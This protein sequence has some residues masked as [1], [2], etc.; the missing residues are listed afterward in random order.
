[1][2]AVGVKYF[3]TKE[4]GTV[5]AGTT[6][7]VEFSWH[8]TVRV[9]RIFFI[10]RSGASLAKVNVT[11]KWGAD[12]VITRESVPASIFAYDPSKAFVLDRELKSDLLVKFSFT[13]NDS[14]DKDLVIVFECY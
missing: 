13:N 9:H 2:I 8:E 3:I 11:I 7:D 4:V 1:M 12:D 10:E 6:K 14:S 5:S